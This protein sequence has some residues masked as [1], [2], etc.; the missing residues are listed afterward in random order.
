MPRVRD[1]LYRFRPTGTP[2]A[3]TAAGVPVDRRG[4]LAA[5]LEPLFSRLEAT[6]RQCAQILEQGRRDAAVTRSRAEDRAGAVLSAAAH[7]AEAERAAAAARV[8]RDA[9]LSFADSR[10]DAE[11]E[12]A[13]VREL[14]AARM[15][16]FTRMVV[17]D[18]RAVLVGTPVHQG[19]L[20]GTR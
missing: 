19:S 18:V 4:D 5:E 13:Q 6:G 2:G 14:A 10:R 12:A 8:G 9:A 16:A 1:L 20:G 7:H 11:R 3:A 17:D 15:T